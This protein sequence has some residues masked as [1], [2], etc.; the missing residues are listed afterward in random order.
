MS[1]RKHYKLTSLVMD[2]SLYAL[3]RP[4][5]MSTYGRR[6]GRAMSGEP[7][8]LKDVFVRG[9]RYSLVAAIT[10]KGYI[11]SCVVPGS[12]EFYDFVAEDVV[13]IY[14]HSHSLNT[15]DLISMQL[16][17][18]KPFPDERSVLILDN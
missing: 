7:A 8:E 10:T 18:M 9:D 6:F 16:P 12:F 13:C 5:R 4:V 17:Q 1:S 14:T 11:A 15:T 2:P 3:M